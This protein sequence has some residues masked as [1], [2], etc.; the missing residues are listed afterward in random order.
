MLRFRR[1][2]CGRRGRGWGEPTL[3]SI[4]PLP[5]HNSPHPTSRLLHIPNISG[6]HMT[7]AVHHRLSGRHTDVKP[8]VVPGRLE[9]F[10]D[11]FFALI[12]QSKHSMF[13][14]SRHQEKIRNMPEW[15]YKQVPVVDRVAVPTGIAEIILR[16]DVI[17]DGIAERAGHG[18]L[19]DWYPRTL[20]RYS[21]FL[22]RLVKACSC[23]LV[24]SASFPTRE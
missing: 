14:I 23:Q 8:D 15:D 6:N 16:Y 20:I 7:M 1:G 9:I 10:L 17:R 2:L 22:R 12:D 4:P 18:M 19:Q 3:P 5:R 24:I 11:H 13:L 21:H